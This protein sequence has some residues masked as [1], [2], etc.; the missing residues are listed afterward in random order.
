MTQPVAGVDQI[1]VVQSQGSMTIGQWSITGHLF[2]TTVLPYLGPS[3]CY[4]SRHH[5]A[6]VLL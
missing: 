5:F 6:S 2:E 3:D 1:L 4:L